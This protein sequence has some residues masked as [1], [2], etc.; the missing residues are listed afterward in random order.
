MLLNWP[1]KREKSDQRLEGLYKK[2][3][4][5]KKKKRSTA[6]ASVLQKAIDFF[7]SFYIPWI[8]LHYCTHCTECVIH[9]KCVDSI[10]RSNSMFEMSMKI[11]VCVCVFACA[12]IC[13]CILIQRHYSLST[14][15]SLFSQHGLNS[16]SPKKTSRAPEQPC[17][18]PGK[19]PIIPSNLPE[20]T[21]R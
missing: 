12:G 9:Y 1:Q 19:N 18:F 15:P 21:L 20:Q 10:L 2:R 14:L 13:L 17:G 5:R 4:K 3:K 11:F 7:F 16:A 8:Q 6:S